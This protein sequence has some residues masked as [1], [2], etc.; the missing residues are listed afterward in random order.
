MKFVLVKSNLGFA[1]RFQ[2]LCFIIQYA[3]KTNRTLVVDWSDEIWSGNDPIKDF[4][5]YFH[6][7][8]DIKFNVMSLR[9]FKKWYLNHIREGNTLSIFPKNHNILSRSYGKSDMSKDNSPNGKFIDITIINS[10]V[11]DY[12][13]DLVVVLGNDR[14]SWNCLVNCRHIDY[15]DNVTYFI[16]EDNFNI[17]VI[18]KK[19]PY[20]AV[21]LR[22]GDRMAYNKH[23]RLCND[24]LDVKKYVNDERMYIL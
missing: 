20:C 16:S 6:F 24:S 2:L 13:E 4:D 8:D 14:R 12:S 11:K 15:N 3:K 9:E 5:Y 19:I 1:D 18:N 21:H 23:D 10:K 7:K 17:N 22:G